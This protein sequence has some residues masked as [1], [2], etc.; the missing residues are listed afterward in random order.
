MSVHD[1]F[2]SNACI[3]IYFQ[4][5]MIDLHNISDKTSGESIQ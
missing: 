3:D 5:T 4:F 1:K 2:Q